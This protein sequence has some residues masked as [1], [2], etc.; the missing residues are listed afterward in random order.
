[1]ADDQIRNSGELVF[2]ARNIINGIFPGIRDHLEDVLSKTSLPSAA[3]ISRGRLFLDVAYMK[4]LSELRDLKMSSWPS[5]D[6]SDTTWLE[7]EAATICGLSADGTPFRKRQ[8]LMLESTELRVC[9]LVGA[10]HAAC[11]LIRYARDQDILLPE[12]AASATRK[13]QGITRK[14]RHIPLGLGARE[15]GTIPKLQAVV[16]GLSVETSCLRA[17]FAKLMTVFWWVT[18][19]GTELAVAQAPMLDIARLIPTQM[20]LPRVM[21]DGQ[22]NEG[23]LESDALRRFGE[24]KAFFPNALAFTGWQ[25]QLHGVSKA[26]ESLPIW[27]QTCSHAKDMSVF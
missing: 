10:F 11:Q 18:D 16:H 17:L 25:H 14:Y 19:Q 13:L 12:D 8:L 7:D 5:C 21:L 27:R 22:E 6:L 3:T 26:L 9:H 2:V 20:T 23:D 4:A 1:M 15:L 24:N